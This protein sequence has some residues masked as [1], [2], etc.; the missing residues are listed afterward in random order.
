MKSFNQDNRVNE[1]GFTL[2]ELMVVVSIIGVLVAVAAPNFLKYQAKAKQSE[3]KLAL[4]AI[5]ALEKAFYSEYN[6]YIPS[7]DAIGY[8]PEGI[9]RYYR[10]GWGSA[11]TQSVTGYSGSKGTTILIELNSPYATCA[12]ANLGG[13]STNGSPF[14]VN[15]PQTMIVGAFGRLNNS[16]GDQY[17]DGWTITDQ[18][19]LSNKQIGY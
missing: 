8:T 12:F 15:D 18:K 14:D 9:K 2:I 11:W 17:C 3:A 1:A 16:V 6:A 4:G 13:V 7:F 5:F 10:I 19:I